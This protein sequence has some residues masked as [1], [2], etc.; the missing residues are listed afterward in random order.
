M[1]QVFKKLFGD[2][3]EKVRRAYR[4]QVEE[5]NTLE[6][7]FQELSDEALRAKTREF[8]ARLKHGETL[9]DLLPEAFAAVREASRRTIELRHYDV[10]LI[11]G[12]VLH[13][14]RI[15]E[16]KTGE[17]KTLVATLPLYLNALEGKGVHLVTVNDYLARRDAGWMG[18]VYHLLDMSVGFIA[19]SYSA[20]F[21]PEYVDPDA[22]LDDERLVHWRPCTRREAYA[23]DITYGT[24]NEFGFD[25][26]RD[27][28]VESLQQMVQRGHHFAIVDE[29]DN[30]LIDE[31]RTPLIISGPAS[32]SSDQYARFAKIV[33]P[34]RAGKVTPD[35]VKKG[36]DPDGDVLLD[37]KSRSVV[38]TEDG[39]TKVEKQITELGEGESVYDPQHSELTHYLE[40]AL[41]ARFSFHRDK[42]YVVQNGE[43][44][45]VD[46]FTG[47]LMPGR[48]WSDGLH[49]AVEA[50]E[51][52]DVRRETVTYATITF[53]NYFRKYDKLA[54]MTGT[55]AT[56]RE[57]FAKIYN[58]EVTIIPTNRKV[59]RHDISDMIYRTQDAKFKAVIAEI[60]DRTA[61]GQPILV[62]TTSVETSEHLSKLLKSEKINH[63]VLNAKQNVDEARVVAQAGQPG[64]VTIATNMAGRGTDIL[65]GG[66]PEALSARH[67]E[68]QGVKQEE[69]VEL[70]QSVFDDPANQKRTPQQLL[71]RAS[72]RLSPDLLDE[73]HR[74]HDY[75]E[76]A[77]LQIEDPT[78]IR[79]FLATSVLPHTIGTERQIAAVEFV[80][81]V[82]NRRHDETSQ[83]VRDT[84]WLKDE[85]I[86]EIWRVYRDVMAYKTQRD[87]GDQAEFLAERV[88]K[89]VYA[90]RGRLVQLTLRGDLDHARELAQHEPGMGQEQIDDILRIKRECEEQ[91]EQI[92]EAGGLHIIGTE[93]HEARR[94]DNQLRGRAGRQGDPGSSSFYL[95]LEDELM[96]RFGRMD[97]VKRAMERLGVDDDMPIQ[98]GI[99]NKSI[100]SAQIRVEGFNF[101]IRK[102]TVEYDDVMNKQREVVYDLRRRVL[103]EA[104]EQRRIEELLAR[105]MDQDQ[106]FQQVFDAI[107][108]T[109]SEDADVEEQALERL[110]NLLPDVDFDLVALA[111]AD[112]ETLAE[113][114]EPLIVQQ[115]EHAVHRMVEELAE[116]VDLPADAEAHLHEADH[117][118][119]SQYV[120][121]L[122]RDQTSDDL[123]ERIKD[124]FADEFGDLIDRYLVEYDAWVRTQLQQAITDATNPATDEVNVQL[125]QRRI[126]PILPE[127]M[128][129]DP[130]ELGTL[131]FDQLQRRLD[132]L[133]APDRERGHHIEL[134]AHEIFTLVPSLFPDP[135]P[136]VWLIMPL[137][138]FEQMREEFL[139]RYQVALENIT[140]ALPETARERIQHDT[141]DVLRQQMRILASNMQSLT[142][143]DRRTIHTTI[144]MR[145]I[146]VLRAVL[147]SPDIDAIEDTLIAQ[148]DRALDDWRNQIG[149]QDLNRYQQSLMLRTIDM[150]WQQYLTAMEDLRQGIGL[151][152]I[153][154][155]D[156]LVQ[157]QTEG[158]RMFH[159]LLDNIDRTVVRNFFRQLPGYQQQIARYQAEQAQR[160]QAVRAGYELSGDG[161]KAARITRTQ[162]LRRKIAK[163]GRNDLCPC[164]SGKKY[165]YCHGKNEAD[166]IAAGE[167]VATAVV[168][169]SQP[170]R[171]ATAPATEQTK[172]TAPTTKA[173]SEQP[174]RRGRSVPPATPA[175]QPKTPRGRSVPEPS[176]GQKKKVKK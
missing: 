96:R 62:G 1:F 80:D 39:L 157:Y 88:F 28:M 60:R 129:L 56:E 153:G 91:R 33:H 112:D 11:G 47:R 102:H 146:D 64:T 59:I 57:E 133:I 154:Q 114:L 51:G 85:H 122:W 68:E 174:P 162:T 84:P 158:Y 25:Y 32:Q 94:I 130:V 95:S 97:T 125:V 15:A 115:Q 137:P 7:E 71:E 143:A 50:K 138:V 103:E 149:V 119:V 117:A 139:H 163:V 150:E 93:R 165:K 127:L 63:Q 141:L 20:R 109:T 53:Q 35:D 173:A 38:I 98:A 79:L 164:G 111:A 30:I 27:N 159:E 171:A 74:Q 43:V 29:V 55:A 116:F 61:Q 21:D 152:A 46:E 101:D 124:L 167:L 65:L 12:M 31:A 36:A 169:P 75:Y 135:Q 126:G 37:P 118:E 41:K 8:R 107:R 14:G 172:P 104:D 160:Q 108:A 105:H 170:A 54:G 34:L 58:R 145:G 4:S 72:T 24:N 40:N 23:A 113:M 140:R 110:E 142:Q 70:A 161:S 168:E 76:Q 52:V 2:T 121:Q 99:I 155:R 16:M 67:L 123:E 92:R 77:L 86:S 6:A 81:A 9:D 69:L 166:A 48:R 13:A 73:L 42:D 3:D 156:P 128:T 147:A 90:A 134:L 132:G 144:M 87:R 26:L 45:I 18:P 151:Q 78:R 120:N 17:G 82:L 66:N 131:S 106:L 83:L 22:P 176:A 100:E 10:Q 44:I 175:Q 148:V 49:Q 5:I 136:L 19:H 89:R